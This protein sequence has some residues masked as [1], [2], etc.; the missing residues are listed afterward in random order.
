MDRAQVVAG[1]ANNLYWT[2]LDTKSDGYSR[3]AKE[4]NVNADALKAGCE[5]LSVLDIDSPI[6]HL[7][8]SGM[9]LEMTANKEYGDKRAEQVVDEVIAGIRRGKI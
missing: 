4:A 2:P 7:V 6:Y 3:V 9:I 8:R 5:F 1:V